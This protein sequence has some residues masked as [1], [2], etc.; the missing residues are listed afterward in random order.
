MI[1]FTDLQ[2]QI[3]INSTDFY[4]YTPYI[5]DHNVQQEALCVLNTLS[6]DFLNTEMCL[7]AVWCL[8]SGVT[9]TAGLRGE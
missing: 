5:A 7:P 4:T 1:R 8:C 9:D 3:S 6:Q 2:I